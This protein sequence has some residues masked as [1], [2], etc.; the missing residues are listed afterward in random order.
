MNQSA[1]EFLFPEW[2]E[3]TI[4]SFV[5]WLD[6]SPR[7]NLVLAR[8]PAIDSN[9]SAVTV[10]GVRPNAKLHIEIDHQFAQARVACRS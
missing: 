5:F 1:I 4:Q 7:S 6:L 3:R 8:E 9:K 10:P 2:Q